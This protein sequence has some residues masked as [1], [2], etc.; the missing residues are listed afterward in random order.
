MKLF[1]PK[2]HAHCKE[3]WE[4]SWVWVYTEKEKYIYFIENNECDKESQ[5]RLCG[6]PKNK[7]N[8]L[9]DFKMQK[10]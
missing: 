4:S 2:L 9:S 8:P 3:F 7:E 1:L 10:N 5:L 6:L